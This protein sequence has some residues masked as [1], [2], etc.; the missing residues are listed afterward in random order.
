MAL[1]IEPAPDQATERERGRQMISTLT[2]LSL[3]QGN[4]YVPPRE[5]A[6]E[7]TAEPLNAGAVEPQSRRWNLLNIARVMFRTFRLKQRRC[8]WFS[9]SR[10]SS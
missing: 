6:V 2:I 1:L 8:G 10:I 7:P 5:H 3:D 4:I 9:L